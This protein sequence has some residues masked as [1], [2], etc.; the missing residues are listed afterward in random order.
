MTDTAKPIGVLI[1]D[2]VEAIRRLLTLIIEMRPSLHVLGEASTGTQSIAQARRLQP[3]VVLLDLSMP[4]MTGFDALPEIKAAAPSA[5]VI[6]LSGFSAAV[7]ADDVLA[8]GA[9]QYIEKGAA[10]DTI[11]DAIERA[12]ALARASVAKPDQ[13]D[14]AS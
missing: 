6:V 12:G 13:S 5:K 3:D 4:D 9:D 8:Q 11:A 7:M 1:C 10:P 14:G 2:D